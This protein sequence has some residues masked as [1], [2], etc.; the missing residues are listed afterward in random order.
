M[1]LL[2][3]LHRET[4]MQPVQ[5]CSCMVSIYKALVKNRTLMVTM[6]P[7]QQQLGSVECGLFAIAFALSAARRDSFSKL[8]FFLPPR[9]H[10]GPSHPVVPATGAAAIPPITERETKKEQAKTYPDPAL[11]HLWAARV[12]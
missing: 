2:Q 11:L 4:D 6:V 10:E 8:S 1:C 12:I 3:L 7:V 5:S 9:K